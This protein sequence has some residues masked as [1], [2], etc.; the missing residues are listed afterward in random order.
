MPVILK[1]DSIEGVDLGHVAY[2]ARN[3]APNGWLKANGAAVDRTTYAL[4]FAA[5]G[6]TFGS[7]NG[8]TTFNVPDLRG[9]WIRSWDDGRGID[10]G[11]TFASAQAGA[12]QNHTH[13]V[14]NVLQSLFGGDGEYDSNATSN[15]VGANDFNSG[16]KT[17]SNPT[18][19]NA[20][21]RVR[22]IA[23]LA[24]IKSF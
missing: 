7:G 9:E 13:T 24:C 23:L 5:I 21:N 2:F 20:E 1:T 22:N 10:S 16:T 4:L 17:T 8:S 12:V 18:N 19:N 3:T 15:V 11:R 14:T 6:T